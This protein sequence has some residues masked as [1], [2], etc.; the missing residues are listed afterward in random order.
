MV[1]G[2]AST[3]SFSVCFVDE[4]VSLFIEVCEVRVL[5]L[6]VKVGIFIS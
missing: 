4:F 3:K 2:I 6:C 1:P 5:K